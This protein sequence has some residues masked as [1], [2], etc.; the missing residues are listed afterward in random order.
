M[1]PVALHGSM[2]RKKLDLTTTEDMLKSSWF[3][4][5]SER[6]RRRKGRVTE[7]GTLLEDSSLELDETAMVQAIYE[8]VEGNVRLLLPPA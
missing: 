3:V 8:D 1:A 5:W 7:L 4:P 2:P 6:S